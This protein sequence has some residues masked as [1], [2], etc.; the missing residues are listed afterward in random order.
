[1]GLFTRSAKRHPDGF[2]FRPMQPRDAG[3]ALEIVCAHDEDDGA[4][5]E[6]TLSGDLSAFYV[7]EV[8]GV[9][10]GFTGYQR[11]FDAPGSAWLSWTYVHE[12]FRR[13]GIGGFMLEELKA[14]LEKRGVERLFIATSNYTEDG[15]DLY[16][17][18][19]RFYE[20]QGARCDLVIDDFFSPGE[21]KYIY[22]LPLTEGAVF[23]DSPEPGHVAFV[24]G[25]MLEESDTAWGFY[26]TET[27]TDAQGNSAEDT[28]LDTLIADARSN[29]AQAIFVSLP[30][31][32]SQSAAIKLQAAGFQ[33]IGAVTDF[34][35]PG[36]ND[37]YWALYL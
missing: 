6:A 2:C 37:I 22:R 19:R 8:E 35:G 18:A 12:D 20:R 36:V 25:D 33:N 30:S 28:G 23:A 5:A 10:A 3:A 21:A 32:L 13:R 11:I 7:V 9:V 4:E 15:V 31:N 24:D 29:G 34:Y 17:D 1:M 16:A 27:E 14:L 26:W